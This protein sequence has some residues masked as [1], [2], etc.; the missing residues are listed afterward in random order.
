MRQDKE[1][2]Q[3]IPEH[4]RNKQPESPVKSLVPGDVPAQEVPCQHQEKRNPPQ[5]KEMDAHRL[6]KGGGQVDVH[7]QKGCNNP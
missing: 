3:Y 2:V 5:V 6:E 7:D 1:H 4:E